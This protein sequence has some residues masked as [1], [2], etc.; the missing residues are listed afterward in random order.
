MA[1]TITTD[2]R[3]AFADAWH[4]WHDKHEAARA[5]RHGFL[6]ITSINWLT[7]APQRFVDAPGEWSSDANGVH[8]TLDDGEEIVVDG[9]TAGCSFAPTWSRPR[10]R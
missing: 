2:E 3:T 8:V 4:R 9:V 5:H 6:A 1:D 7:D 10:P